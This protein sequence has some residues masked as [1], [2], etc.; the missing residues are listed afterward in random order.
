MYRIQINKTVARCFPVFCILLIAAGATQLQAGEDI[1]GKWEFK[2]NFGEREMKAEA[3]F[4]KSEDGAYSAT[5]TPEMP[6]QPEGESME[7]SIPEFKIEISDIR[8]LDGVLTFI[9]KGKFGENEFEISYDGILKDGRLEGIMSGERGDIP[10]IATRIKPTDN[11]LGEWNI[12]HKVKDLQVKEKLII[13][14]SEIGSLTATSKSNIK[15]DVISDVKFEDGKLCFNRTCK[16]DGNDVKM[17]FEGIITCNMLA[18]KYTSE[19]GQWDVAGIRICP[20]LIG[21]WELKTDTEN[22]TKTAILT[23][24]EDMTGSYQSSDADVPVKE[25]NYEE[26]KLNFKI[27][28]QNGDE[29]LKEMAFKGEFHDNAIKGEF[30]TPEGI[31]KITGTKIPTEATE[32]PQSDTITSKI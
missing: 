31:N 5:W 12:K 25:L 2:M 18:G 19:A 8:F 28:V 23:I 29:K 21:K 20:E 14:K 7:G 13:S 24:N 15:E 22:G 9:Q 3:C 30:T 4:S 17:S 26:G 32:T 10:V 11:P 1:T 27:E 6:Q 16:K